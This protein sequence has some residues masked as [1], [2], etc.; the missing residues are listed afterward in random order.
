MA[1]S[2]LCAIAGAL[3]PDFVDASLGATLEKQVLVDAQ[4]NFDPKPINTAK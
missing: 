4:G 2:C 3:P 1:K